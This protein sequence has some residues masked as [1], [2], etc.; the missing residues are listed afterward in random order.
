[1]KFLIKDDK[2][3][4]IEEYTSQILQC[5]ESEVIKFLLEK[6]ER[7]DKILEEIKINIQVID[8]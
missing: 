5:K 8:S 1:M 6:T 7:L 4:I 2:Y 3:Y